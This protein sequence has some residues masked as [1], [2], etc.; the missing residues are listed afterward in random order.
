MSGHH[1][2]PLRGCGLLLLLMAL[3][4]VL[5]GCHSYDGEVRYQSRMVEIST[6]PFYHSPILEV[7]IEERSHYSSSGRLLSTLT[8]VSITNA[9]SYDL[10]VIIDLH[11]YDWSE[12]VDVERWYAWETINLGVVSHSRYAFHAP[13]EVDLW[14]VDNCGCWFSF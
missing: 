9:N 12:Y 4:A 5:A 2:F 3:V 1:V 11:G 10:D 6:G 13:L 14:Y 8:S 7:Y